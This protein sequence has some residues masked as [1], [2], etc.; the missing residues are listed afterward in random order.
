MKKIFC[1]ALSFAAVLFFSACS[2][3]DSYS[4]FD[5]TTASVQYYSDISN[6]RCKDE[7]DNGKVVYIQNRDEKMVCED[8]SWQNYYVRVSRN[9][10]KDPF[11][12]LRRDTV[13]K[14]DLLPPCNAKRDSLVFLVQS[15][16]RELVC[17]DESWEELSLQRIP[18]TV[19]SSIDLPECHSSLNGAIIFVNYIDEEMVCSD[20]SWVRLSGW[21]KSSSSMASS[22]SRSSSSSVIGVRDWTFGECD[23]S[24]EGEV[25]FDSNGVVNWRNDDDDESEYGYYECVDG[26]WINAPAEVL[27]T[28]GWLPGEDGSFR[29]GFNSVSYLYSTLPSYCLFTGDEAKRFYVFEGD[30][31]RQARMREVCF[32]RACTNSREGEKYTA[33]GMEFI[34]SKSFWTL[35][36]SDS[37]KVS[38]D[39]D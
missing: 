20:G 11:E 23:E 16:K 2:E 27:D 26:E 6:I 5:D 31:W 9:N 28:I 24:R 22:S 36:S 10:K 34:C 18:S 32:A 8:G 37:V 15:I 29:I 38:F 33:G 17:L 14:Y 21:L 3:D 39:N 13:S 35:V 30:S 12:N 4:G 7:K 1:F 25:A 19:S